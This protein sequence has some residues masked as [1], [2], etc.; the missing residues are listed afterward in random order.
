MNLPLPK[1]AVQLIAI[2][3]FAGAG[4]FSL[5]S[6]RRFLL[7]TSFRMVGF[8]LVAG[9]ALFANNEF[10]YF[11]AIFI[12]AS[13]ITSLDFLQNL[14]AIIRGSKDFFDWRRSAQQAGPP[15]ADTT[16]KQQPE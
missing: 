6:L 3:A 2:A 12:V 4:L 1:D 7:D 13:Q 14:A 5:L 15:A 16:L 10:V 9:L 8:G 11:A